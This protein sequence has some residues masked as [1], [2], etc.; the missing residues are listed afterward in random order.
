MQCIVTERSTVYLLPLHFVHF[1]VA[2]VPVVL[3]L[4]TGGLRGF[5]EVQ[6]QVGGAAVILTRAGQAG[7]N[8]GAQSLCK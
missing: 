5:R 4:R 2:L 6:H 3:R 1:D 7:R 8:A